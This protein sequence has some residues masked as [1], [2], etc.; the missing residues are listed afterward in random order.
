MTINIRILI[1]RRDPHGIGIK[2]KN[3]CDSVILLGDNVF[4][5]SSLSQDTSGLEELLITMFE[6]L[7][8]MGVREVIAYSQVANTNSK[9]IEDIV[10]IKPFK[11]LFKW[12]WQSAHI[13]PTLEEKVREVIGLITWVKSDHFKKGIIDIY[14]ECVICTNTQQGNVQGFANLSRTPLMGWISK[15]CTNPD[16]LSHKIEKMIDPDYCV[17]KEAFEEQRILKRDKGVFKKIQ[18]LGDKG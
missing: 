11:F 13:T 16:C 18:L 14:R 5:T 10:N 12:G 17:P 1:E 4:T 15:H 6:N 9:S 7:D 3:L 2:T 8:G